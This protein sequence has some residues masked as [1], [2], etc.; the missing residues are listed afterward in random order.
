MLKES[1]IECVGKQDETLQYK[2]KGPDHCLGLVRI[3]STFFLM[4]INPTRGADRLNN[5]FHQS[6]MVLRKCRNLE[7]LNSGVLLCRCLSCLIHEDA[8]ESL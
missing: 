7:L 8:S 6:Q 5:F 1:P 4:N 2:E 3:L